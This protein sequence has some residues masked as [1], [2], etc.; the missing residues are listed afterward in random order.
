MY[1]VSADPSFSLTECLTSKTVNRCEFRESSTF[2]Q[3]CQTKVTL[4]PKVRSSLEVI[5]S[6]ASLPAVLA[7]QCY[8]P[9]VVLAAL[10]WALPRT[11]MVNRGIHSSS[12]WD[13]AV[14]LRITQSVMVLFL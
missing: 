2:N 7:G 14:L 9:N 1:S 4:I 13:L 11:K 5:V 3:I 6:G 10:L 12:T 8:S